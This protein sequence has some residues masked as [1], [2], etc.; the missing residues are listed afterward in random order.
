[1]SRNGAY[2]SQGGP[3]FKK[4][5][6]DLFRHISHPGSNGKDGREHLAPSRPDTFINKYLL[7]ESRGA[8]PQILS[9]R[10][11]DDLP[12]V[13]IGRMPCQ[14]YSA[15]TGPGGGLASVNCIAPTLN[16]SD[17][18]VDF[19]DED[20]GLPDD[21]PN[22]YVTCQRPPPRKSPFSDMAMYFRRPSMATKPDIRSIQEDLQS[23]NNNIIVRDDSGDDKS[24]TGLKSSDF[25]GKAYG[26]SL[27]CIVPSWRGEAPS[28][29]S[30]NLTRAPPNAVIQFGSNPLTYELSIGGTA[31]AG[32]DCSGTRSCENICS[33]AS[34]LSNSCSSFCGGSLGSL[35]ELG[36]ARA[37]TG[38]DPVLFNGNDSKNCA[39]A[40]LSHL[41]GSEQSTSVPI[42][43]VCGALN[44][45]HEP[46]FSSASLPTS[47]YL[48]Y[49]S[50]MDQNFNP[51][52]DP[53]IKKSPPSVTRSN[54][55]GR[56]IMSPTNVDHSETCSAPTTP[57]SDPGDSQVCHP[58]Q[59]SISLAPTELPTKKHQENRAVSQTPLQ[60]KL[61]QQSIASKSQSR[62]SN[63]NLNN[64]IRNSHGDSNLNS[65]H[66]VN[67]NDINFSPA[68]KA[69][70]NV[71]GS[72]LTNE[73]GL[74]NHRAKFLTL[75]LVEGCT[76]SAPHPAL[77]R[78]E[79]E[80]VA[81]VL[82]WNR[83]SERAFGLSTT[84]YERHPITR[85][86]AGNP[87]AD[88]FGV[89]ARYNSALLA[90]ADGVNWGEKA[91]LAARCA[92]QGCLAHLNA[93]IFSPTLAHP[94][95]T[96]TDLFVAL[97]R[98]FHAAHNLILQEG[99]QL[100]TLTAAIVAPVSKSG[101]Y[102]VCV[103]NVGDSLAYVYSQQHGVREIT[104]ASH[105]IHSMRDM[106]DALGA[107]GPVD[108]LN[109]ELNNLTCSM[110]FVE[111][112]DLVF[113]TS[114]GISD[115][116]DPVV[117]KF[118]LPKKEESGEKRE[119]TESECMQ[120]EKKKRQ[121]Q[122]MNLQAQE[123]QQKPN[124]SLTSKSKSKQSR[125]QMQLLQK[126]EQICQQNPRK[127]SR[128]QR[129]RHQQLLSVTNGF[130]QVVSRS[131]SQPSVLGASA[132]PPCGSAAPKQASTLGSA[133]LSGNL[134]LTENK[135]SSSGDTNKNL[136]GNRSYLQ[137]SEDLVPPEV[138]AH[139]RHELTLLRMEDLL[140]RGIT[141]NKPVVNAQTLCLEMV[142][143]AT[144]LTLA[145]RR[146]LE[147]PDLYPPPKITPSTDGVSAAGT[148]QKPGTSQLSR[149]EQR[150]RRRK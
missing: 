43:S 84:L 92:V 110:T 51:V 115:N 78:S 33:A 63:S 12:P 143:F 135:N 98:S 96:T 8:Q 141:T 60:Q 107:L 150:N 86:R 90:L 111:E 136:A 138:E 148:E 99:G 120:E 113:L 15:F 9:G 122:K 133:G 140:R 6:V 88:S 37:Q 101:R 27:E 94:P 129:I 42:P 40:S 100:T 97:L 47:S 30:P 109:P 13:R 49:I 59:S 22:A 61:L 91:C 34:P 32:V 66:I 118:V 123:Q 36:V 4:K 24:R 103:C 45:T 116:F 70:N 144:K 131:K 53:C 137:D 19:I 72:D 44:V 35:E 16:I 147:D 80:E 85:E 73:G 52:N 2:G 26:N 71:V 74:I 125:R 57:R 1:M 18:D 114:D 126:Y 31:Y 75:D 46:P 28:P 23:K 124:F 105:D 104:Q 17:Q 81:G 29:L 56:H 20:A 68:C 82:N 64:N 38:N 7:G 21:Q 128:G 89:V 145:K 76:L 50:N 25:S 55:I 117:G 121:K 134:S 146:V 102:V 95:R 112:G 127:Q 67:S 87:I 139:Q 79:Q 58:Q 48:N 54:P 10:S 11:C 41:D 83:P 108:G 130:K 62:I 142:H 77:K 14:V 3:S 39:A 65:S 93:A 119:K 69:N 149:G 132:A 5:F 106:R